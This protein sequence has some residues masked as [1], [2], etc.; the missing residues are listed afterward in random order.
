[1]ASST[2]INHLLVD[3]GCGSYKLPSNMNWGPQQDTLLNL[4]RAT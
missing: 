1:M 4:L 3:V 2:L